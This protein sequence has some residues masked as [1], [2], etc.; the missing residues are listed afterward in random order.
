MRCILRDVRL[1][2][3]MEFFFVME[4]RSGGRGLSYKRVNCHW[5]FFLGTMVFVKGIYEVVETRYDLSL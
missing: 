4:E 3:L 2:E 1:C 5:S